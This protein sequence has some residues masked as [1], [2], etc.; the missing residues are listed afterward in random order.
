MEGAAPKLDSFI[1]A[2]MEQITTKEYKYQKG[3]MEVHKVEVKILSFISFLYFL[4]LSN[5]R[6]PAQ[7]LPSRA[8]CRRPTR[9][10]SSNL[11]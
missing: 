6:K 8:C 5:L 11:K 2:N 4:L 7:A 9:T 10:C 3:G 1:K